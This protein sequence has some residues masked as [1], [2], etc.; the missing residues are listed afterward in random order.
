VF[1]RL[2]LSLLLCGWSGSRVI[3]EKVGDCVIRG[4][5]N[6]PRCEGDSEIAKLFRTVR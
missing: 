1:E 4:D 5:M 6:G 2:R 3:V